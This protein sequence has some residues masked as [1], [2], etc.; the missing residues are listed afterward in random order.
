VVRLLVPRKLTAEE[1]E[2]RSAILAT[3]AGL[4]AERAVERERQR[5]N[6]RRQLTKL[7]RAFE[8]EQAR[9]TKVEASAEARIVAAQRRLERLAVAN[10]ADPRAGQLLAEAQAEVVHE[11][12]EGAWAVW[13][14][15][16]RLRAAAEARA[17]AQHDVVQSDHAYTSAASEASRIRAEAEA[18]AAAVQ[19]AR[20]RR[21]RQPE[22]RTRTSTG[23][24]PVPAT[25][26]RFPHVAA[27]V[28]VGLLLCSVTDALSRATLTPSVWLFWAGVA[29][30]VAP[31]VY[32]LCSTDA[33]PGER[34]AIV[35]LFGLALY[36]VKMM[37][38]PFGYTM[39]DEF[40]HAYNAQQIAAHHHLFVTDYLLPVTKSFPGL[41]GATNALMALTGMS[42]FGAGLIVVAAARLVLTVALFVLFR[43]I[44]GS[45]RVAGLGAAAYAGNSNFLLWSA[46]FAYES[47]ALP[48]LVVLLASL[49]ERSDA[50]EAERRSWL[51]AIVILMAAIVVSHHLT[52]YAMDLVLVVLGLIPIV[53]RGR[54]RR[55]R[56]W[57][58]TGLSLALTIGW[59]VVVASETVGYISPVISH[60]F[61]ETLHTLL[62]ESAP[63]T[64]FTSSP[65]SLG[66]P[67]SEQVV[68]YVALGI[69]L[70]AL[71]FGLLA[72]WRRHRRE[73]FAILFCLAAL[74]FFAVLGLRL[75]PSAWE[76]GN[77]MSEFLYVGLA[78]VVAYAVLERLPALTGRM[79]P[80]LAAALI[81][82]V[83]VG[84]AITGWP[85]SAT[86]AAPVQIKADGRQIRSETLAVGH[87]IR[88]H[89][90]TGG[91]AAA[92]SDARTI[93]LYGTGHVLTGYAAG[94]IDK[95]EASTTI[96]SDE[97]EGL[98]K[99][100]LG[101]FVTDRRERAGD[102]TRGYPFSVTRAGG[103]PDRLL[104][105]AVAT[106]FDDLPAPRVYDSGN[107]D[108]YDLRQVP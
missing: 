59:L 63:R 66:T 56:S 25:L 108:I 41:E 35:C 64:P 43:R 27:V 61:T 32:R 89:L 93:Q 82:V 102:N 58:L 91:F 88:V 19:H 10:G 105:P 85:A 13:H 47:L 37:R 65:G 9:A 57:P 44:S 46:Q 17:Q 99:N 79:M 20:L 73:P 107:V 83:V 90:P 75:E 54:V 4:A 53:A 16:N 42:S 84:G 49:A 70:V 33:S 2:E 92:E 60:A 52:S 21:D 45:A 14:A 68:A 87:W 34:V 11:R 31:V 40:F 1:L 95:L 30:I 36:A 39:P 12:G 106:R 74:G 101:Y 62:G 100:G 72:V 6:A 55:L 22:H 48:L 96:T 8:R 98:H 103:V 97:I 94:N 51:T 104:P 15:S 5:R 80:A 86:L 81:A 67:F 18:A 26:G 23:P 29:L 76:I 3:E 78:F 38:D 7:Q 24:P 28:A 69:L 77:R 71:P 50:H